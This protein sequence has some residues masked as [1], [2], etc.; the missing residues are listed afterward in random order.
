MYVLMDLAQTDWEKEVLLRKKKQLFYT[1]I[2]LIN[3][4][5]DLIKTFAQLQRMNISHRD[6]K[7]QN[8]LVFNEKHGYKLADF[9]EAKELLNNG[10]V[11]NKQT[12]RGT[13]LYMSPIL[14]H[15]LRS[16]Q[17]LKYINHNTYKSDV[18]SFGYCIL[19][20][21][22]LCYEVLYDVRELTNNYSTRVVI[23]RYLNRRY[24]NKLIDLISM[25]LDYDEKSRCDFIELEKIVENLN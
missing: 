25:M 1:E 3:I 17:Y 11:T 21:A 4:L 7:P 15:A 8:I 13:E 6:I 16:K 23:E 12:L 20:A 18:Y 9:G 2:E 22:A 19:F 24:S 10:I 14:F 5:K